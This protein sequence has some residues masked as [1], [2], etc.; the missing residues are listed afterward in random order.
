M[1]YSPDYAALQRLLDR[2][3]AFHRSF[4]TVTGSV[5]AALMLS[6]AVYWHP[7]G[8][9]ANNWFYKTQ[10]EWEAETGMSRY[11]QEGARKKLRLVKT[12][13]GTPVWEEQLRGVPAKLHYHVNISALFECIIQYGEIPH[14]SMQETNKQERDNPPN[15][16]AE[17]P[18]SLYTQTTSYINAKSEKRPPRAQKGKKS[19]NPEDYGYIPRE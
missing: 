8:S 4:V 16:N 7:R 6:Q 17:N 3:I 15:L 1:N 9:G 14:T 12:Q 2:P 19:Y 10:A 5:L 11:E 18:Q 13:D